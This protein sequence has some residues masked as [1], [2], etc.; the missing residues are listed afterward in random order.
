MNR[1]R[2]IQLKSRFPKTIEEVIKNL[3]IHS[4]KILRWSYSAFFQSFYIEVLGAYTGELDIYETGL[5]PKTF[6]W[7]L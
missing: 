7:K 4:L 6:N 1:S 5:D 3:E 2:I